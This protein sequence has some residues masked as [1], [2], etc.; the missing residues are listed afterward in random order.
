[1]G[2]LNDEK[3]EFEVKDEDEP[4]LVK[5]YEDYK[6]GDLSIIWWTNWETCASNLCLVLRKNS[7]V[8]ERIIIN[9]WMKKFYVEI[10]GNMC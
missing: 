9:V 5:L 1:M 8:F 3:C 2:N 10:T 7:K 6:N 4:L